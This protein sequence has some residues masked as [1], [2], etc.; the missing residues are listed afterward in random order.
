[1]TERVEL[2]P[3]GQ[4]GGRPSHASASTGSLGQARAVQAP[5]GETSEEENHEQLRAA[6]IK[7]LSAVRA[8]GGGILPPPSTH[9]HPT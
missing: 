6:S 7:W 4:R 3:E 8:E 1:M 9:T 2:S 5:P